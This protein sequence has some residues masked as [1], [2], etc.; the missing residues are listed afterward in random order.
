[1]NDPCRLEG[2]A[3]ASCL[4]HGVKGV[5]TGARL[6][7]ASTPKWIALFVRLRKERLDLPVLVLSSDFACA[8]QISKSERTLQICTALFCLVLLPDFACAIQVNNT[9]AKVHIVCTLLFSLVLLPDFACAFQA[10]KCEHALQMRTKLALQYSL[11]CCRQ[12]LHTHRPAQHSNKN[13][14]FRSA[15]SSSSLQ[16]GHSEKKK[17]GL[18]SASLA[19]CIKERSLI[20]QGRASPRHVC[21]LNTC[22]GLPVL[23]LLPDFKC[24]LQIGNLVD[25]GIIID[26]EN[27]FG[28]GRGLP[29]PSVCDVIGA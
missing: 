19:A 29:A 10:S 25:D 23:V 15:S 11:K 7:G 21:I 4:P 16:N 6:S 20:L 22:S 9:F 12:T 1:M 5:Q 28:A 13:T 18:R 14:P 8:I 17:E 24:A 26:I 2:Q 27:S 3:P